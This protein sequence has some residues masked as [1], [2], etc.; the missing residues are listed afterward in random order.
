MAL[1]AAVLMSTSP[2]QAQTTVPSQGPGGPILV[3]AGDP[4][5]R[6]YAEILRA[7]GLNAFAVTDA[8]SVSAESLAA[9]QVVIL[10]DGSALSDAQVGALGQWVASGGNLI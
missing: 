10:A 5:G 6:Y 9:Y 4:L 2:A 3:V 7:E 8:P 1:V